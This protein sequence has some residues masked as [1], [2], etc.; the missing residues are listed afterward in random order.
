M[1]KMNRLITIIFVL[2]CAGCG[3]TGHVNNWGEVTIKMPRERVHSLLGEPSRTLSHE[4][5]N[6]TV[7]KPDNSLTPEGLCVL[8]SSMLCQF[9]TVE[10]WPDPVNRDDCLRV[11][12]GKTDKVRGKFPN[13]IET[14]GIRQPT[15]SGDVAVRAAPDK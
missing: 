14:K 1:D 10:M 6:S 2:A 4:Q 8:S 12:Y 11:Y 15:S 9:E 3:T 5:W 7:Q 13:R